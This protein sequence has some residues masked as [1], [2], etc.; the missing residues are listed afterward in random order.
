MNTTLSAR[1]AAKT[2]QGMLPSGCWEWTGAKSNGYGVIGEGRHG[3]RTF[4]AHRVA[5]SLANGEIPAGMDV[6]HKCDNRACVRVDHLFVGTRRDNM[7]DCV[8]KGRT[9]RGAQRKNTKLTP[10]SVRSIRIEY[11]TMTQ[12][13]LAAK[14]GVAAST[15]QQV[16]DGRAWRYVK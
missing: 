14:Y 7:A 10:E 15:I 6:C 9:A 12:A 11:E 13:A 1:L 4:K 8:A 5:W 3:G 2:D 16:V